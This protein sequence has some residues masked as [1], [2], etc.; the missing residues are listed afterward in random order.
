MQVN[1][2][3]QQII[4]AVFKNYDVRGLVHSQITDELAYAIGN[5]FARHFNVQRCIVGRDGRADSP[6]LARALVEGLL[7]AGCNV[8][9]VGLVS[10]PQLKWIVAH[11]KFPAG[12]M[13]TASHNPPQYNGFK[14]VGEAGLAIGEDAGLHALKAVLATPVKTKRGTRT[15]HSYLEEF[16]RYTLD[17]AGLHESTREVFVDG[18]G[19][20]FSA[21]IITAMKF[22]KFNFTLFNTDLDPEFS[23]HPPDPLQPSATEPARIYCAARNCIGVV[24]DA[25]GDRSI[26]VDEDGNEMP[27]DY[28]GAWAAAHTFVKGDGATSTVRDSRAVRDVVLSKG[29]TFRLGKVGHANI[30]RLM[31]D[32]DLRLGTE[33]SGHV[34][35]K[36]SYYAENGLFGLLLILKH[37]KPGER[38]AEGTQAFRKQYQ[39][40][41]E[42]NFKVSN[43]A[44]VI[45]AAKQHYA[46]RGTI[47]TMDGV[48][49]E[50][51][52]WWVNIRPSNT[53]PLVRLT[54][55]APTKMEYEKLLHEAEEL[56]KPFGSVASGHH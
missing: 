41:P 36:E 43:T 38:L 30:Q 12:V 11:H 2:M 31:Y 7:D 27:G 29:G 46:N 45:A 50:G 4:N 15:E 22:G 32:N 17:A 10:T 18:S 54:F 55:E 42:I 24:F 39:S 1:T 13:V 9:D 23:L 8:V 16:V 6:A 52:D 40:S 26:F 47:N 53:E 33:K 51:K 28:F 48:L 19:G 56:I 5:A 44:E 21:E 49:C 3:D 14:F 37:L 20:V 34:F 25:D 35:F